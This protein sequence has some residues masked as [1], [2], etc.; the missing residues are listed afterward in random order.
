[1]LGGAKSARRNVAFT[2]HP[3][4]LPT[5]GDGGP[6]VVVIA[7]SH[8]KR[9]RCGCFCELERALKHGFVRLSDSHF[10]FDKNVVK[11]MGDSEAIHFLT[12]DVGGAVGDEPDGTNGLCEF[13][14]FQGVF[15][16]DERLVSGFAIPVR[17][18]LCE[19]LVVHSAFEQREA[20]E[21]GSGGLSILKVDGVPVALLDRGAEF[22]ECGGPMAEPDFGRVFG[23]PELGK[24]GFEPIF[25][26]VPI[27]AE[28]VIE[29]EVDGF[30]GRL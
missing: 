9:F 26:S 18:A 6:D 13:E 5:S 14:G 21:F 2:A 28:G 10:A 17:N 27:G 8:E 23:G 4:G 7:V 30:D 12:L 11:S 20:H 25:G 16:E 24:C 19:A 15:E 29:V 3:I 1:M 22:A